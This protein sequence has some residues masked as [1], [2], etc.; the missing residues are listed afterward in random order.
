MPRQ[1]PSHP[2]LEH[3]RKQAKQLLRDVR[4]GDADSCARVRRAHPRWSNAAVEMP[5]GF[6]LHDAQLVVSREFGFAS[7][8]RLQDAAA[9][10]R[11]PSATGQRVLIT[12]GA[13][14]IGSHLADSLVAG[15]HHV[16]ALD[17]LS[18]GREDNVARLEQDDRFELVVGDVCDADL[19]DTLVSRVDVVFH[20]A[21]L[22]GIFSD[23]EDPVNV[24]PTNVHGTEVVVAAASRHDVRFLLTSTSAVYGKT[25]GRQVLREDSDLVLGSSGPGWDYAI[26]KAASE[27]LTLAHVSRHDL[28]AT[29]VRLFNVI[30]PRQHGCVVPT[31]VRQATARESLTVH[32]D[33]TQR[34]CFT[35]VRDV[36]EGLIR[37]A[38]CEDASGEVVNLGSRNEYSVRCLADMVRSVTHS[39]SS[40]ELIP[41]DRLPYGEA[42]QQHI[43]YK[44]PCLDRARQLIGYAAVHPVE[45]SLH[46]I[47]A[48]DGD[49]V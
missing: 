21:A 17:D 36:V 35:D 3:F 27:T 38:G 46:E 5:R 11:I 45:E 12:G 10:E 28:R 25:E 26:T 42:W 20:L 29:V 41:Y 18:A 16:T 47:V 43:P 30:G 49:A 1:F 39:D 9:R 13:G 19:V 14:F 33:G 34:R 31:F 6:S 23:L 22:F 37:L 40:I 2:S 24:V 48:L 7:W 15:G 8:R 44:V 32:G 4:S